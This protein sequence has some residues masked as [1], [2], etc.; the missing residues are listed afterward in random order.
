[1]ENK[2]DIKKHSPPVGYNPIAE[3]RGA[4]FHNICVPF[5]R[6]PVWCYVTCL[7][8]IQI[9]SCGNLTCL[10]ELFN[11]NQEKEPDLIK[12][13]EYK[14]A[15]EALVKLTMIKPTYDEICG[16]VT[17]SNFLISEKT[18]ELEEINKI[19]NTLKPGKEKK[20]LQKQADQIEYY[21]GFL[22]PDD[23]M[24]FITAWALGIEI[25][26]IKKL[27][28]RILLDAAIMAANGKNNPT[29]HLTGIFTDFQKDDINKNAWYFYNQ[30]ME[31]KKREQELKKS[32]YK[33]YGGKNK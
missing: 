16:M 27:D 10:Y 32:K 4:M 21:L 9:K 2:I 1:M 19:I 28:R 12:I 24:A 22:L 23:A 15:Q 11:Q 29:D 8:M 31:D 13:I 20:E 25:T 3:I 5:N 6:T 17:E 26:D 14:N 33:W 7:N 18:A 30:Y